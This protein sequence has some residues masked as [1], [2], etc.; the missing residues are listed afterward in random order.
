ME[1]PKP[2]SPAEIVCSPSQTLSYPSP[3]PQSPRSLRPTLFTSV[4]FLSLLPL[5]LSLSQVSQQYE[6]RPLS[7]A[8]KFEI[9]TVYPAYTLSRLYAALLPQPINVLGHV[10]FKRIPHPRIS[11]HHPLRSQ[12]RVLRFDPIG[13]ATFYVHSQ[14]A[15]IGIFKYSIHIPR[16]I[17]EIS[18]WKSLFHN[19]K[20]VWNISVR[21]AWNMYC[22][23]PEIFCNCH[24]PCFIRK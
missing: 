14:I 7:N 6:K 17:P 10:W 20:Y 4:H 16:N 11:L 3:R 19:V 13:I 9:Q 8:F 2:L 23:V 18:V 12:V 21:C 1:S 15:S 24:I 5:S 22:F